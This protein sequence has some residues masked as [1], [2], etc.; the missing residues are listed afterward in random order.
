[1]VQRSFTTETASVLVVDDEAVVRRILGDALAQAG[2]RVQRAQNSAEALALLEH[3]GADLMLLDLQLGDD[4]GVD[5]MRIARSKWPQLPII[6]LTAHG[7]MSSAIEAV[8]LEAADYLLKPI[9]IET[10]RSRV[11]EVIERYRANQQR[12][13]RIRSMYQQLQ[14]IVKDEGLAVHHEAP[15]STSHELNLRVGDLSIDVQQHTVRMRGQTVE[16]TPTE[17][18]IL[19]TLARQPGVVIPCVQLIQAFQN[20]QMEEDEARTVM[21]PHIVRL[22]RKLEPDPQR[23]IYIQ[24]VRG[25]GYRWKVETAE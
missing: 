2:Y 16:V 17:F 23:P 25:I 3:P 22:R 6:I 8:R 18:A 1:M 4:D 24:S 19:H 7:S 10:L 12:H 11:A 21:R 20:V 14:E 13:E 15:P 5:V 9:G